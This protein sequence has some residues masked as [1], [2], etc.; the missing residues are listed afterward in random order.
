MTDIKKNKS[1]IY[2]LMRNCR[3]TEK[4]LKIFQKSIEK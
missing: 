1:K 2:D 4:E 3:Y